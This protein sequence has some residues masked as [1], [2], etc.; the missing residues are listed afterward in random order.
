MCLSPRVWV[1]PSGDVIAVHRADVNVGTSR[2]A[3]NDSYLFLD[4]GVSGHV[5][6]ARLVAANEMPAKFWL[7][8]PDR[9]E[10]PNDILQ[11][12]DEALVR[13]RA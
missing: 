11:E 5:V 8:H 3:R 13:R 7:V 2:E 6:G 9:D 10:L 4:L 12:L 1:S